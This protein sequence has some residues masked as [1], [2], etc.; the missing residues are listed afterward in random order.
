MCC[1][2]VLPHYLCGKVALID[3]II[4]ST[5]VHVGAAAIPVGI[6]RLQ[7]IRTQYPFNNF[8]R[9]VGVEEALIAIQKIDCQSSSVMVDQRADWMIVLIGALSDGMGLQE[10]RLSDPIAAVPAFV[11]CEGH[12]RQGEIFGR[13]LR[14]LAADLDS[15]LGKILAIFETALRATDERE[16]AAG[17]GDFR[18]VA[19]TG[20]LC[21]G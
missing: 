19:A 18:I 11:E 17:R 10:V 12:I 15:A 2:Q 6:A 16:C 1:A 9:P 20:T 21:H 7:M 4:E 8:Q 5:E 14:M 13:Q 3:G